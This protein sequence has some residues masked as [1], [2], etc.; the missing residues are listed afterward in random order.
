MQVFNEWKNLYAHLL[1]LTDWKERYFAISNIEKR[2][3]RQNADPYARLFTIKNPTG[4]VFYGTGKYLRAMKY[5][6]AAAQ[7]ANECAMMKGPRWQILKG[8]SWR[9]LAEEFGNCLDGLRLFNTVTRKRDWDVPGEPWDE[10]PPSMGDLD[11][12][13]PPGEDKIFIASTALER[14]EAKKAAAAAKEA[15]KEK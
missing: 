12:S 7:Y 15:A 1:T 14:F 11:L 6:I 2:G 5:A 10:A 4:H 8:M 13:A 9:A 3:S